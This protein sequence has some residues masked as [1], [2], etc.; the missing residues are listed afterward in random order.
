MTSD[1]EAEINMWRA[2]FDLAQA[3]A[4]TPAVR[5]FASDLPRNATQRVNGI[6]GRL[7]ELEAGGAGISARPLRVASIVDARRDWPPSPM[8]QGPPDP[9]DWEQWRSAAAASEIAH[10]GTLSWLRSRMPRYPDLPALQLARGA[11]LRAD[12]TG[13]SLLW[14]QNE[15]LAGLQF[16]GPFPQIAQ[17]LQASTR[18]QRQIANATQVLGAALERTAE[19]RRLDST[20]ESLTGST[21]TEL[22]QARRTLSEQLSPVRIDNHS[23]QAMERS[24]YRAAILS[25][26]VAALSGPAKEYTS[27]F[28]EANRVLVTAASDVFGQLAAYGEPATG[29]S[30]QNI[31]YRPGSHIQLVSFTQAANDGNESASPFLEMGQLM[32][33]DSALVPD[34]IQI[35]SGQ[36]SFGLAEGEEQ[37]YTGTVLAGTARAWSRR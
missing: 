29:A 28:E 7:Q 2:V 14:P 10:Q 15:P 3:W 20:A 26:A 33:L 16:Q 4:E 6:P 36:H 21:I 37:R 34:C 25:D 17:T 24:V 5:R 1:A 13:Y 30:P 22:R 35:I 9:A 27:S 23:R 32:W 8:S 11:P 18:E 12:E 31:D 19:W